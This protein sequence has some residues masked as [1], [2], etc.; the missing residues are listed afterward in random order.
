M[1]FIHEKN[2]LAFLCHFSF[3]STW[4]RQGQNV[5]K[6]CEQQRKNTWTMS[7]K[8]WPSGSSGQYFQR[9][10]HTHTH[11]HTHTF[12]MVQR[13][14]SG[15]QGTRVLEGRELPRERTWRS[16]TRTRGATLQ[17]Q[18]ERTHRERG[19]SPRAP[20]RLRGVCV[21]TCQRRKI[22]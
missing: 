11:T 15:S 3:W 7:F 13:Q 2:I 6:H 10:K 5:P 9:K 14:N 21:S 19:Y 12:P 1:T 8:H 17:H 22:S 4:M 18:G 20:S 16:G